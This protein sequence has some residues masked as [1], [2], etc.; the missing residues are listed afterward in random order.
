M[1]IT[2]SHFIQIF[3]KGDP[4]V[5]NFVIRF[6]N[7]ETM[8][9][10]RSKVETQRVSL[11]DSARS[12]GQTETS[13]TEFLYIKNQTL[14]PN[15]YKQEDDGEEDDDQTA[16]PT[17]SGT[18]SSDWTM[19]SRNASSTSLRSRSTTGGSG[20]PNGQT[21]SRVPPPRF[22]IPDHINGLNGLSLK[23]S[24]SFAPG[25]AQ[26]DEH[27][28]D[29]Y[30]SPT[31]E[32][33]ASVRSSQLSTYPFPRQPVP[34]TGWTPEEHN[35][36]NTA[37]PIGRASSRNGQPP[38]N[39][40]MLDGRTVQRPSLPA[41]AASQTA[42]LNLAS[43]NR[44]ASTPDIH[45]PNNAAARRYVN[46]QM[47]LAA[48]NVPVPP[49]PAHM[50]SSMRAPVNRSQNN[51]PTSNS[52]PQRTGTQSP[53]LARLL[54]VT[55][56]NGQYGVDPSQQSGSRSDSR[57]HQSSNTISPVLTGIGQRMLNTAIQQSALQQFALHSSGGNDHG[58]Q[59][60]QLKVKIWFDPDPSHVTI[61]VPTIIKH[62]S[63]IDRIDSKME[64]V[65]T[66]SIAKGTARL[67]YCDSDGD[68][69][70]MG[71][72]EDVKTAIDE[73]FITHEDALRM[74]V[75][76]DFELFWKKVA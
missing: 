19:I 63:L 39:T 52:S 61:V 60:T 17:P 46:G 23:V 8:T 40:Y 32:S 54:G 34:K 67:R 28:G 42:M 47:N 10:W 24:T 7:E 56:T 58:P 11:S 1:C 45:N 59:I 5:E 71:C 30:F 29:S 73:W 3:W 15:P 43:R 21:A 69:I 20:P 53:K 38:G 12:S 35:K 4:G 41:M 2:G 25:S 37:P 51:S 50:T 27:I 57:Q 9:K 16:H 76:P 72:D 55:A 65:S 49:I 26:P 68:F 62:Q 33:P 48:E 31:I 70:T 64:R 14:V 44:S 22:P 6:P 75:V 66:S 36:H 13:A 74:G 18:E